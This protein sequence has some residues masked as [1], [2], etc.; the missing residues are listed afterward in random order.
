[1]IENRPCEI[2]SSRPATVI[3][4]RRRLGFSNRTF[5]CPEC[6][7]ERARLCGVQGFGVERVIGYLEGRS[8][9]N[10]G[11]SV[12]CRLCGTTLAEII[13]DAKPGCSMCYVRFADEIE[14][15]VRAAQGRT[16][17]IGKRPLK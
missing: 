10:K 15:A 5:V 16:L 2:C 1:M 13:A 6:A 11:P 3:I 17:H 7:D 8:S 12:G 9:G 4:A 14:P